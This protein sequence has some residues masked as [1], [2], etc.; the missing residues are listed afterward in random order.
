MKF[1]NDTKY[2]FRASKV[3]LKSM[4]ISFGTPFGHKVFPGSLNDAKKLSK[5]KSFSFHEAC[6]AEIRAPKEI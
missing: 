6:R 3:E 1:P 2:H 5:M 4:R